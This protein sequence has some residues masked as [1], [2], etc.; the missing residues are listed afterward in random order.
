[1][2]PA[3][4]FPHLSASPRSCREQGS[5]ALDEPCFA[6]VHRVKL[7]ATSNVRV[8]NNQSTI[9]R[10]SGSGWVIV[11]NHD[12]DQIIEPEGDPEG[13]TE[14][15]CNIFLL[16]MSTR[17]SSDS[18]L[19]QFKSRADV[20]A[21]CPVAAP[22]QSFARLSNCCKV[23][24]EAQSLTNNKQAR[25]LSSFVANNS[26]YLDEL[27]CFT[28]LKWVYVILRILNETIWFPGWAR[29]LR[30]YSIYNY[31][32]HNQPEMAC[33]IMQ[34]LQ[35]FLSHHQTSGAW[36]SMGETLGGPKTLL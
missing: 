35:H 33:N 15:R 28:N 1:M 31:K 3:Q 17:Q 16:W 24:F 30:L 29:C 20:S 9:H 32:S 26:K 18:S 13:G 2:K 23:E 6:Q 8:I 22:L 11:M 14:S 7:C 25:W 10:Y 5:P 21:E 34:L 12:L 27:Q 19:L 36:S 4:I